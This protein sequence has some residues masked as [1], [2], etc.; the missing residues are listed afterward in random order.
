MNDMNAIVAVDERWSIGKDNRLLF[1]IPDDMKFFRKMT[2]DSVVVLGRRNLESFPGGKPLPKRRNIVLSE[3][4]DPGEGYEVVRDL[5]ELFALL[6]EEDCPV[7]VIGGGQVYRQL[8]PWCKKAYVTK[9][10]RDF[11]GDVFFPDLDEDPDWLV[12]EEGELLD[13]EGLNYRFLT[14]ENAYPNEETDYGK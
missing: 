5:P 7:F 2:L 4:L 9:M 3:T 11:Q 10:Y 14:Y 13:H 12:V 8:L 6:K 1:S